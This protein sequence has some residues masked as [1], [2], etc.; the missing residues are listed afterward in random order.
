MRATEISYPNISAGILLKIQEK[1]GDRG[2]KM[3]NRRKINRWQINKPVR[4]KLEGKASG[5]DCLLKDI[6]L[7]GAHLAIDLKIAADSYIK[8]QLILSQ[9]YS[10]NCEAWVAWHKYSDGNDAYGFLFTKISNADKEKIY[11]FVFENAPHSISS[12]WWK[13]K[14]KEG[15]EDMDDRRIFQR[16]NVRFPVKLLDLNSG[17]E[18][19]AE[20]NDI[21]AKGIGVCSKENFNKNAPLE[22]WLK[23]PDKGEPLYTRGN[24]VWS[25]ADAQGEYRL[26]IDLEK[27]DLM[28][29]SR[30]LRV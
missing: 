28:G 19:I 2:Y 8:F 4:I 15:G 7:K 22:A 26:G 17:Q 18:A 5:T 10:L 12:Y 3:Q 11:R 16:F 27:A 1:D 6:N 20:T 23:I 25:T 29:L 21:S 14:F 30:V 13:D 24:V 9:D